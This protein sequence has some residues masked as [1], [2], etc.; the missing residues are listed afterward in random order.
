MNCTLSGDGTDENLVFVMGWGNKADHETV[1]WLTDQFV[2]A[3]YYVHAIE[4]PTVVTD[5]LWEYV[6]PIQRYVDDLAEFRLVGH[7]TGGL[8]GP[9]IDGATTRTYL[10]PW[11][12][13]TGG[14]SPAMSLAMRLPTDRSILP[15]GITKEALG[16]YTTDR[17]I[18]E[19]P[20]RAAP[21]FLREAA[22]GHEHR[23]PVDE[24]A[25]VFCSLRDEVVSV[26]AIGYAVP[27]ERTVIYDGGHELFGSTSR[28][29][30]LDTLLAVVH[31]GADALD[32]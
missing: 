8:I 27:S 31:A 7:S 9:Y 3:G 29:D 11:W 15:A 5:F 14:G 20:R 4:I 13:F 10:S 26:R 6:D 24:D 21:S 32:R 23:P 18:E 19:I 28:E 12:G 17:Q 2:D 30:H 1:R 22:W 25:V 16:I